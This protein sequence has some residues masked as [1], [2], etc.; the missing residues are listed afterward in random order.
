MTATADAI[1]LPVP[2]SYPSPFEHFKRERNLGMERQQPEG[3]R[4]YRMPRQDQQRGF[5]TR[6]GYTSE[7]P[8]VG[9]FIDIR[10]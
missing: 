1:Y 3:H 5:Y 9:T 10:V 2:F 8:A 4:I 7:Q 6:D